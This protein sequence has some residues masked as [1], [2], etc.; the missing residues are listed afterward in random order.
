MTPGSKSEAGRRVTFTVCC[1]LVS[2]RIKT[3]LYEPYPYCQPSSFSSSLL[4]AGSQYS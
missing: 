2:D 3:P 4:S 1:L